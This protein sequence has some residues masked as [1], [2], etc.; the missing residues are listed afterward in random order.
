MRL[1]MRVWDL[2]IRVF[3]GAVTLLLIVAVATW[4]SHHMRWHIL[5]GDALLV[6]LL[7]RLAWGFVGSDTAR[8]PAFLVAPLAGLGKRGADDSYGH[9]TAGGWWVLVMLVLLAV[10]I[11]TGLARAA[12]LHAAA[13]WLLLAAILVHLVVVALAVQRG[14]E[15]PLRLMLSGKK[16]MPAAQRAPKMA[17]DG[18]AALVLLC[19]A[20][21]VV[22]VLRGLHL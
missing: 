2:P 17:G 7:W 9:G 6:L 12:R 3:H 11:G 1:S 21:A 22:L 20:G 4:R 15:S 19:A 5:T 8:W 18:F 16:R 13:G 14:A 10:Q